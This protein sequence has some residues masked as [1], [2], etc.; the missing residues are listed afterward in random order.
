MNFTKEEIK[1]LE[2][3]FK[4]YRELPFPEDIQDLLFQLHEHSE[5]GV[6]YSEKNVLILLNALKQ[7]LIWIMD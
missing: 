1:E 4:D 7:E 3:E 6:I 5:E 2:I